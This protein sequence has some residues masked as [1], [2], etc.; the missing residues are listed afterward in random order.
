MKPAAASAPF[1][2]DLMRLVANL[3]VEI[4]GWF[5]LPAFQHGN[6]IEVNT[7]VVGIDEACSG[8]RSFQS[9]LMGAL[10]LGA[11][12][13]LLW[14]RRLL[15]LARGIWV[16]L[17]LN[18]VRTLTLP[19]HAS[20]SG[21][22]AINKWHDPA[23]LTIFFISFACLWLLALWLRRSAPNSQPSTL[24]LLKVH[25]PS[26]ILHHPAHSALPTPHSPLTWSRWV[27]GRFS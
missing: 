17:C 8:I 11:L 10:F 21:I 16:A 2:S 15:L 23:G 4:L 18:V 20:T 14:P 27:A 19:W 26:S 3:T 5:N 13:L 25:P 22:A 7:G 24:N 6:L 12:Y 9:T 1:N